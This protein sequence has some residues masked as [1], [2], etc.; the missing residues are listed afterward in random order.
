MVA[1]RVLFQL[2]VAYEAI[3]STNVCGTQ[4]WVK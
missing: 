4:S 1:E 2:N 3:M